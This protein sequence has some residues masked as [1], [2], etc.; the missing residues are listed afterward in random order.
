MT[1]K[2]ANAVAWFLGA[3]A[4]FT[5]LMAGT[6]TG[7]EQEAWHIAASLLAVPALVLGIV[8]L[9]SHRPPS[10]SRRTDVRP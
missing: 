5:I 6:T 9:I 3:A 1:R 2:A 7:R 10:S 4:V 8:W